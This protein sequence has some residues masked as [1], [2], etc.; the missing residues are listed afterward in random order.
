MQPSPRFSVPT[1][2]LQPVTRYDGCHMTF[3]LAEKVADA[4]L[5]E[6]YVLYPYRASSAKNQLRWQFGIV[7][8]R[9]YVQA[10]GADPCSMQTE[11]LVDGP[12]SARLTIR[13]RFLQAQSRTVEQALEDGGFRPVASLDLGSEEVSTWDEGI[14]RCV[15]VADVTLERLLAGE[16]VVPVVPDT[17]RDIEMLHGTEG[18]IIGRLVRERFPIAATVRVSA[19]SMGSVTR[20]RVQLDNETPWS[21]DS[22]AERDAAMRHALLGAHT[23]LAVHDG[24]FVSLLDPPEWAKAA[25]ASCDNQKTWPVMIGAAGDC[26]IMLSSPIIL[27]DYPSTAPESAGD[28]CDATEIDEILMLRVM[29]LTDD[30]KRQARGTDARARDIIERSDNI[31]REMFE[32][33]HGAIRSFEPAQ[34]VATDSARAAGDAIPQIATDESGWAVFASSEAA[35]ENSSEASIMIDGKRVGRGSRV[36][37]RPIRRADSMDMF[38]DGRT[39]RVDGVQTDL[40]GVRYVGVTI[41]DDP[42]ADLHE[43]YGRFFY[44]YPDELEPLDTADTPPDSLLMTDMHDSRDGVNPS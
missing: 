41:E 42:A 26:S 29:T 12:I 30:E 3:S 18:R 24:S 19:V 5:Y 38:L 27:Y 34:R 7:A 22:N 6:G 11:V 16:M 2:R 14:E 32:R 9:D 23:L 37:L 21:G 31:P 15:D 17:G 36:V 43:W 33:L 20:V 13:V 40:E 44:F 28:L 8:P 10:G 25:V 39:A 35:A 4:V 1:H